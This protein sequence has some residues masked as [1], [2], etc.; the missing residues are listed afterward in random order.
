MDKAYKPDR[1]FKIG[2]LVTNEF[3]L[4]IGYEEVRIDEGEIGLIVSMVSFSDNDI[5]GYD[6]VVLM[7]GREIFFFEQELALHTLSGDK[8]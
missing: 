6:Y 4:D 7:K 5:S 1:K 3:P 2:D 8:R